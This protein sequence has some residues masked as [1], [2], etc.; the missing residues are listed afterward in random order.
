MASRAQA[1]RVVIVG[2]GPGGAAVAITLAQKGL[3]P[4]ILETRTGPE[5][6]VGECLPPGAGPIIERLGLSDNLHQDGHLPSYGNRSVWGTSSPVERDF[7]F[8]T[9][10]HG[11]QLDRLKFEAALANKAREDGADWR[12][13]SKLVQCSWQN[14]H[15]ALDV[16]TPSGN[17]TLE[18]DFVV[19]ATGRRSRLARQLGARQIRYDRLVGVALMLQSRTGPGIRECLTLVEAA[20]SGWWYSA[21]LPGEKLMVVY[22]TDSDLLDHEASKTRG[23]F[24]LLEE[25]EQTLRR[26]SEGD[27]G[28]LME[29]RI[30]QA[31]GARLDMVAGERW[32]AVGDAATAFD[33]LSSYGI[34]SALGSGFYAASAIVDFFAGSHTALPA[35]SRII[36]QAYAQYLLMHYE[37]YALEQRWPDELFWRR[38]HERSW[39]SHV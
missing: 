16:Q 15:W 31:N 9:Q 19:D 32:L 23:W 11:W 20:S 39:S 34:S 26:V 5:L 21:R 10:G 38:R 4:V 22:V 29:P 12:Y 14:E 35:Y 17:E 33:P 6:K 18:A 24:A 2:G 30:L 13:G 1:Q 28:P 37:H 7:I 25:T 27:Y 36:E 8:G 3:K